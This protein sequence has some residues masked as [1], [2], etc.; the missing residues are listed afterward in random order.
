MVLNQPRYNFNI[1]CLFFKN[2]NF[3]DS[4]DFSFDLKNIFF[5][6]LES[7]TVVVKK[8]I[9]GILSQ[10]QQQYPSRY[11]I[12]CNNLLHAI[13]SLEQIPDLLLHPF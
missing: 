11:Y 7:L 12:F 9:K 8:K 1:I 5:W 4:K 13:S 10:G 2:V 3:P 6:P